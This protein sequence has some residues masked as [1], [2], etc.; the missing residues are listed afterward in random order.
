MTITNPVI[1][2]GNLSLTPNGGVNRTLDFGAGYTQ[3]AIILFNGGAGSRFGWGLNA[4]EMQFFVATGGN[5]RFTWN[6]GGDQQASGTN[7]MMR[8]FQ[9][10]LGTKLSIAGEVVA[11]TRITSGVVL[12]GSISGTYTTDCSLGNE[13]RITATANLT[14][15]NP[16]N[17]VDGQVVT[18]RITQ[19]AAGNKTITLGNK[20]RGGTDITI[21]VTATTTALK[22]DYLIAEYIL[23]DDKW[24]VIS[25][26]KGY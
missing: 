17:P 25:F 23:A 9:A 3:P 19:P 14:L 24:D 20:F 7:E 1:I 18:W 8:L 16:T 5:Y 22:S 21:P 6:K 15:A 10:T 13:F 4:D 12:A 2:G 26:S 11:S